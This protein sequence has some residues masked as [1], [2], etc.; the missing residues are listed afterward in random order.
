MDSHNSNSVTTESVP[1][2][3]AIK[4]LR[5]FFF[6]AWH[7]SPFGV[8]A[9][10]LLTHIYGCTPVRIIGATHYRTVLQDFMQ[11]HLTAREYINFGDIEHPE[12]MKAASIAGGADAVVA[13]L[14][15]G[16]DTTLGSTFNGRDLS[17]GEWHPLSSGC[18]Y[19]WIIV[20]D[21]HETLLAKE[22]H[23]DQFFNAQTQRY[24]EV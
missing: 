22:G 4:T 21:N 17:T 7:V 11:Y 18:S 23:Y 9:Q 16:Y 19:D 1:R 2:L 8:I 10:V 5:R 12:R 24:V 6:V 14:T 15:E 3:S 13:G 20:I